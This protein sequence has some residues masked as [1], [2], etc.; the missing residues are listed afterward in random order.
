V[1]RFPGEHRI[2][3]IEPPDS[4]T[5]QLANNVGLSWG[6]SAATHYDVCY[7][8][9]D[10]DTCDSSWQNHGT[11]TSATISG[12]S[13]STTYYW[14]VRAY[15]GS[16]YA[17]ANSGA[18]W[19]FTTVAASVP[20][21]FSKLEPANGATNQSLTPTLAWEQSTGATGYAYC[22]DTSNNNTCGSSWV[23]TGTATA[24]THA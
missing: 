12:L 18:W 17:H 7:D 9:S 16:S 11:S 5:D 20:G 4:A 21:A 22:Y 3:Q 15:N 19:S 2:Q 8:T 24:V 13:N 10:N 14:Q 23:S 1:A 6:P